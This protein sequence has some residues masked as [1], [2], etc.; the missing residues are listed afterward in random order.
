MK[1]RT[2]VVVVNNQS[3][4]SKPFLTAI[5]L[6]A[7]NNIRSV[8]HLP[9]SE[10]DLQHLTFERKSCR[11]ILALCCS[12]DERGG[13]LIEILIFDAIGLPSIQ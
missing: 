12:D 1:H 3:A 6:D 13:L 11:S 7:H 4:N 2:N 9:L 10:Y 5:S 8:F